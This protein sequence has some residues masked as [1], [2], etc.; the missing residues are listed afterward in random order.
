[1]ELEVLV[2][3]GSEMMNRV[4]IK[5]VATQVTEMFIITGCGA[6]NSPIKGFISPLIETGVTSI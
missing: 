2:M 1:M 6:N 3:G 5:K 4:C